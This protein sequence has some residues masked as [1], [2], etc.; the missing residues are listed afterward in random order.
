M[1]FGMPTL[2]ENNTLEDN[3]KLCKELGLKFVEL[4]MNLPEYQVEKLENVEY[5]KQI[6][7]NN[8]IYFTIHLDENLNIADFNDAVAEAYL[9]TV[10]RTIKVAKELGVPVLNMH[11]NHGVYFTLPDKRVMLFDKYFDEYINRFKEFKHMC[12][13]AIGDS[14]IAICIENTDGFK[15]YEKYVIDMLLESDK[16]GLTWDI[17]HSHGV[18]DIDE[19]FIMKN[20]RKLKHFHI[21][22]AVGRKNHLTLGTGEV[23]LCKRMELARK[24]HSRCV[25]E[26]K[27]IEALRESVRWFK[28]KS[29]CLYRCI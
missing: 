16:F 20:K 27:T 1:D 7:N 29:K 15:E 10:K 11:M 9:N 21:H 26:T 14:D 12:E 28:D 3:V 13:D 5:L 6:A 25:I 19:L 22:D 2:I 18:D 24:S 23:D 8:N 4:N 17:G